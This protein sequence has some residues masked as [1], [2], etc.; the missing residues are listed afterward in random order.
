MLLVILVIRPE[1]L[2]CSACTISA[3]LAEF[4]K[5]LQSE[6]HAVALD[7]YS[8]G[9]LLEEMGNWKWIQDESIDQHV[10]LSQP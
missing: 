4:F 6:N 8:K 7:L 10:T 3:K 2:V 9:V 1:C 5:A